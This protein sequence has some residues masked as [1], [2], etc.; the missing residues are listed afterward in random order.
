MH[1]IKMKESDEFQLIGVEF[2]AKTLPCQI[3]T[4]VSLIFRLSAMSGA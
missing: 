4:N 1:L 2:R 3:K